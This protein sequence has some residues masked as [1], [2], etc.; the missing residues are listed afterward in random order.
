MESRGLMDM[1][2][3][4]IL[5]ALA[6]WVAPIVVAGNIGAHKGRGGIGVLL[7]IVFGWIGAIIIAMINP[8]PD[9]LRQEALR[10]GFA[11]PFCQEPVRHG[12]TV[13]PHCQRDLPP[14]PA[15]P[16]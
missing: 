14:V 10:H 5:L 6:F 9:A 4:I 2:A 1:V 7:G 12:A 3:L 8:T 13:C 16:V 11:C 15:S